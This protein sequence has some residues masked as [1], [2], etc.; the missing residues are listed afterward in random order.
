RF[1]VSDQLPSAI[2][3]EAVQNGIPSL[4][5]T[6]V[7]STG[8]FTVTS[9][10]IA[11]YQP[12]DSVV[13]LDLS[14][15]MNDDSELK[16][17]TSED[18]PDRE[19]VET[20]LEEIWEEDLESPTYGNLVFQPEYLTV[21]G[22]PPSVPQEPQISVTF[23]GDDVYVESSKDLS[24]V[25]M[26]FT[27][28]S[29]QKIEGLTSPTG[30]FRGTGYNYNKQIRKI[31]VKSGSNA[32]GEGP[33]Y[34]ERFED[35]NQAVKE[36]FGLNT[37]AY[38]Y[39]SGSWDDYINYCRNKSSVKNAGYRKKYGGMTLVNYWL[40]NKASHT[41]TP[42]LWKVRAQP[43]QAVKD[44]TDVFME[45][46]QEVDAEDRA[47]LVVYNSPS[48]HATLEHE[49]TTEFEDVADTVQHRQA[50]HYHSMTNIG[51]GISVARE[52][53][54]N[55]ARTG[56]FKMIVLMTD[57]QANTSTEYGV[58]GRQYAL[59]QAYQA[60]ANGY[61]IV[62]ISLGN[63]ADTDLMQEIA[64]ITEGAHFNIPGLGSGVTDYHDGLMQTFRDIAN[65]RPLI[66]V[67]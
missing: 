40:E 55:H 9:E 28:G 43:I 6:I 25:V 11:G 10:S 67:K 54:N 8:D 30:A 14:G 66:L 38:P 13:V 1:E 21:V 41:Q 37:V 35:T 63:G 46:I 39:P 44:A 31:W 49:L 45:Y 5:G 42:D 2:R 4:F 57:G 56:A 32:S 65:D 18:D 58:S 60:A 20:N 64:D 36:A 62:T 15:S 34:G 16:R 12:R 19:P 23:R 27:D 53:L 3:V 26:E 61:P 47:G 7:S 51:A 29:R 50:G 59:N 52:E 17:I 24:N 33:G 48:S 22:Q